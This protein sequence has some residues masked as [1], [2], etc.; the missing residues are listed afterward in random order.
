MTLNV[1]NLAGPSKLQEAK[2]N[3]IVW[4]ETEDVRAESLGKLR[5]VRG[6]FSKTYKGKLETVT[7]AKPVRVFITAEDNDN[8]QAPGSQV[9]LNTKLFGVK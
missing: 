1:T 2:R 3:Y 8:P 5:S 6:L 9:V 7:T 4:Y